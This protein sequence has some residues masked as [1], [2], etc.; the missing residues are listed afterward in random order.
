MGQEQD[1]EPRNRAAQTCPPAS[2]KREKAV[3]WRKTRLF[4][5]WFWKK[6]DVNVQNNNLDTYLTLSMKMSTQG[7]KSREPL[8][9]LTGSATRG[10]RTL[11]Y[12]VLSYRDFSVCTLMLLLHLSVTHGKF[13]PHECSLNQAIRDTFTR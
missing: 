11:I 12:N 7:L 10:L 1:E 8:G 9:M 4:Q 2:S 13:S 3:R 5:S 6:L